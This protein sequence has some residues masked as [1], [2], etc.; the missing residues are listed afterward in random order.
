MPSPRHIVLAGIAV[1]GVATMATSSVSLYRLGVGT[2][3]GDYLAAALP[4]AL[5]VG[6]AVAALAW[7]TETGRARTWGRVTALCALA[8]SL[9]GNGLE[10]ALALGMVTPT[11]LLVLLV[12]SSIPAMLFAVIHLAALM[13]RPDTSSDES[14]HGTDVSSPSTS[15]NTE[16]R[17]A[18][19]S[20]IVTVKEHVASVVQPR[21]LT[22]ATPPEGDLAKA[23]RLLSESAGRPTLR[24]E[25]RIGDGHAKTLQATPA[26][27]VTAEMIADLQAKE[28]ANAKERR[29][30]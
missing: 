30:A 18:V 9:A 24:R 26:H 3:I 25:L 5:D 27:E 20:P 13:A 8:G 10:H 17:P 12:G 1:V 19:S 16:D 28:A 4:V 14:S 29:R 11:L 2:G 15:D 21:R 7:L 23:Q 6:G 22:L